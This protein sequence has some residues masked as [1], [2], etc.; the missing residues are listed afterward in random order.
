VLT[1]MRMPRIQARPPILPGSKVIRSNI[2]NLLAQ[3]RG[4]ASSMASN[5]RFSSL[6]LARI[7]QGI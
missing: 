1:V 4:M 7:I 5:S 6:A 2:G 3:V